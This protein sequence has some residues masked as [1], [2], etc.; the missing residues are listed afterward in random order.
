MSARRRS[1]AV[2]LLAAT[3]TVSGLG[4]P[5]AQAVAPTV[6]PE[7][8]SPSTYAVVPPTPVFS[9][10]PVTG[11]V[12]YRFQASISASFP[13]SSPTPLYD[14]ITYGLHASPP[15]ALPAGPAYW[16]VAAMDAS[17]LAGPFS[18][19]VPFVVDTAVSP[20]PTA[21]ADGATLSYPSQPPVLKWQPLA[22]AKTYTVEVD[23]AVDFT[24]PSTYVNIPAAQYALVEPPP[25]DIPQYWRVKA[26]LSSSGVTSLWS[27]PRSFTATWPE[28]PTPTSPANGDTV[29]EVRLAWNPLDGAKTYE[30]QVSPSGDFQNNLLALAGS[31]T[32]H[33][34][35]YAPLVEMKPQAYF[36][37]VRAKDDAGTAHLGG[38]SATSTFTL[39]LMQAPTNLTPGVDTSQPDIPPVVTPPTFSWSGVARAMK[40][41][42]QVGVDQNFTASTYS[43]CVTDHIRLTP[44]LSGVKYPCN[45]GFGAQRYFWRVRGISSA[46]YN[47]SWS[48]VYS[49]YY[50]GGPVP[51]MTGPADGASTTAPVLSWNPVQGFN[52][53]RVSW[54]KSDAAT[55]TTKDVWTTSFSPPGVAGPTALGSY[56]WHVQ[57]LDANNQLGAQLI[58]P[59]QLT[60]LAPESPPASITLGPSGTSSPVM[61]SMTWTPLAGA[62]SY[63]VWYRN[64]GAPTWLSLNGTTKLYFPAYTYTGEPL[65][66]GSYEWFVDARDASNAVIGSSAAPDGTFTVV[67]AARTSYTGPPNCVNTVC[68]ASSDVPTLSWNPVD[69]THFYVVHLATDPDFANP[70]P[71]HKTQ[72]TTITFP[73]QLADNQAGQSYYWYVLPCKSTN[74][75]GPF[76][77]GQLGSL[78]QS[79]RKRTPGV[80]LIAPAAGA[81]VGDDP[82][83]SWQRY[84]DTDPLASP[85]KQYHFQVSSDSGFATLVDNVTLDQTTYTPF[86]KEYPDGTYYW[87]VQA[88]DAEGQLL[89]FSEPRT[90]VK[91]SL[92]PTLEA[93]TS[94]TPLPTLTWGGLGYVGGY[95]VEVYP[96][97]TTSVAASVSV[98]TKLPAWTPPAALAK[99]TYTWR[100]A[101]LDPSGNRGPWSTTSTF[102]VSLPPA[103]LV[104]PADNASFVTD[105]LVFTWSLASGSVSSYRF[106]T[107]TAATFA[108][109]F[110]SQ[111]LTGTTWATPKKYAD[112][113]RYYWRVSALDSANNV[114]ATS[115][116]RSFIKDSVPPT[117]VSVLPDANLPLVGNAVTVAFSEPVQG[118]NS[119]T[120]VLHK[121]GSPSLV[122]AGTVTPSLDKKSATFRPA[123]PLVPGRTYTVSLKSGITDAGG[124]SLAPVAYDRRAALSVDS[125]SPAVKELW[126]TDA[127]SYASGG[128]F[129]A[130]R[131]AGAS[132]TFTVSGT[133]VSLRGTK[134]PLGGYAYL[135]LD[136]AKTPVKRSFYRSALAYKQS[137]YAWTGLRSGT[138]TL[139]VVV[140]GGKPPTGSK[141]T[142]V[143]PDAVTNGSVYVQESSAVHRF[144][145][146]TAS[147]AYGGSYERELFDA[148]RDNGGKPEFR[149]DLE[150]TGIDLYMVKSPLGGR[151]RVYVDSAYV[152]IDLYSS[153][154]VYKAKVLSRTGLSATTAHRIRVISLTTKNAYSKGYATQLD[155]VIVR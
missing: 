120:L 44:Y 154:T 99:N 47:G 148:A 63:N 133:A 151:V 88:V 35:Q 142:Y 79:F 100:V 94:T 127:S 140:V 24:S 92:V 50:G 59:W 71:V 64:I 39:G 153:S 77:D 9:W 114:L 16:R 15:S 21:P 43:T 109:A 20:A 54:K 14:V 105:D 102:E 37:R 104:S 106:E 72:Y 32:V 12:K 101:K 51:T 134:G 5:Q 139:R 26:V 65:T 149:V 123:S 42:L 150:G 145:K 131:Q 112:G 130:S 110:E 34:T 61:P 17:G 96:G 128:A 89:T 155:H 119:S 144:L 147:S 27:T 84:T 19:T 41:E 97:T 91:S 122:V 25:L 137:I 125:A 86:A 6:A 62:V 75:C 111:T 67:E 46:A 78:E 1:F 107:S 48:A 132:M 56:D 55:Y 33:G 98:T 2:A 138:H 60:V 108:T 10:L 81:T 3:L 74:V 129:A 85:P 66:A 143:Y 69:Y 58:A 8:V 31:A 95:K 70:L 45:L 76:Q 113:V 23:D 146:V 30:V 53:Y 117:V 38:W 11:A 18:G 135:Y 4:V 126:D 118:V 83:F 29:P 141:G 93:I 28:V 115:A 103:T 49:F 22:G 57:T 87:R 80:G 124:I 68:T 73:E 82:H 52:K 40:Y 36:W 136:G 152:D 13:A 121:K 7:T 116:T 90:F